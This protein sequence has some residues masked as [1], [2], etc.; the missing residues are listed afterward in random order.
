MACAEYAVV[1]NEGYGLWGGLSER[2]RSRVRKKI[3][4]DWGI[5][6]ISRE[7]ALADPDSEVRVALRA[8]LPQ[9]L[10]EQDQTSERPLGRPPKLVQE[11]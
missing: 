4:E 10:D 9:Y 2:A 1:F 11:A 8:K 6:N 3:K 7:L 5:T